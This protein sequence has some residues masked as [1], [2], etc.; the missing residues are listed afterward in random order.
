MCTKK[1]GR[2]IRNR[3]NA[4][5]IVKHHGIQLDDVSS[6]LRNDREVVAAAVR[7]DPR[8]LEYASPRLREDMDMILLALMH[9][10]WRGDV[11]DAMAAP[12]A[13]HTLMGQHLT[14]DEV[15][16]RV[17]RDGMSLG[18][19]AAYND[20]DEIVR[21]AA[22]CDPRALRFA[23]ER[24]RNNNEFVTM[25]VSENGMTLRYAS[26]E[27]QHDEGVVRRA[28]ANNGL[29]FMFASRYLREKC[30]G[31]LRLL[32]LSSD[33]RARLFF[34]L[35]ERGRYVRAGPIELRILFRRMP[36]QWSLPEDV[37][38]RHILP[39]YFCS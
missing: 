14:R 29:A 4:L 32:A 11:L 38:E 34:P 17:S 16:D 9:G 25:V 10:G 39:N 21:T 36:P 6:V 8:A 31:Q 13:N 2:M 37:V 18:F 26:M 19:H 5:A 12:H 3:I 15:L 20:D 7:N 28:I 22:R 24:L 1:R 33:R 23:S 35:E 30:D 27:L